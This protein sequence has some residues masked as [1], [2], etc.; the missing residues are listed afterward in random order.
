MNLSLEQMIFKMPF[1]LKA[2]ISDF[3]HISK[4]D[5]KRKVHRKSSSSR[6]KK[7][8]DI[9]F[10]A[11]QQKVISSASDTLDWRSYV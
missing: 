7:V 4:F 10:T 2:S 11:D 6:N 9:A 1:N 8:F 3:Y 5:Y